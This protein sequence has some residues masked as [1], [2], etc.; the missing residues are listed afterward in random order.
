ML[1]QPVVVPSDFGETIGVRRAEQ[2][3]RGWF[4]EGVR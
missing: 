4:V 3:G 2:A 1:W